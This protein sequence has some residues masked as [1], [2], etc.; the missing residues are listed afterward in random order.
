M[1]CAKILMKI[2]IIKYIK[3]QRNIIVFIL[4]PKLPT[5]YM[6]L[7]SKI[8]YFVYQHIN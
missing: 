6:K 4:I 3:V 2:L 8:K 1:Q 7:N 5:K